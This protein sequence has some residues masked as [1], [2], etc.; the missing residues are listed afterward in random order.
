MAARR[1]TGTRN[2]F[3]LRL[4]CYESVYQRLNGKTRGAALPGCK[5]FFC[6]GVAPPRM[7]R[8][9][10]ASVSRARCARR[11]SEAFSLGS[12]SR[13]VACFELRV[14]PTQEKAQQQPFD[15]LPPLLILFLLPGHTKRSAGEESL[16]G[17][18]L[19]GF[20][21]A[22]IADTGAQRKPR[23]DISAFPMHAW[24][25]ESVLDDAGVGPLDTSTAN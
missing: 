8:S 13:Q 6:M 19:H 15:L 22:V 24:P 23:I 14:R 21:P 10:T 12:R 2:Y 25:F 5:S 16:T 3:L 4:F 11:G 17:G 9:R 18:L 1:G 7:R 20:L